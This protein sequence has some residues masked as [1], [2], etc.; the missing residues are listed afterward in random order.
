M[1]VYLAVPLVRNRSIDRARLMAKAIRDSGNTIASSWNLDPMEVS[2]PST[3]NVFD[4]DRT[5]SENADVMVADVTDPST[6]VGMEIM[7]AYKAGRRIILVSQR[8]RR[9]SKML[10][11]MDGKE[12]LEYNNESE[13]YQGLLRMLK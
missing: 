7:A 8:G 12:K 10:E 1:K 6:G 11:D 13:I 9:V 5:G 3:V 4:R 2:A